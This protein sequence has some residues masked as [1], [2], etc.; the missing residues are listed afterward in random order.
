MDKEI[1]VIEARDAILDE[2]NIQLID[3]RSKE[4]FEKKSLPR[5]INVPLKNISRE[6]P[7]LD[8]RKKTF[9]LCDDGTES[10][11]A[12]KLLEACGFKAQVIRGGL[13]DWEQ[14]IT[15]PI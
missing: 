7:N 8:G 11:Q 12:L 2:D 1:T 9:I 10:F 4:L 3:V 5:F 6:I 14:I 13:N 15:T